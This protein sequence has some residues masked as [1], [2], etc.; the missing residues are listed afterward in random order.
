[1]L[2]F[3]RFLGTFVVV[4]G[5]VGLGVGAYTVRR[6]PTAD[7]PMTWRRGALGDPGSL[8]P[9]KATTVIEGNVLAELFEGLVSRDAKGEL[10]PGVASSWTIDPD[11]MHYVFALRPNARWSNGDAVTAHD[12]VFAFR[13]LMAPAT[14]APYA[15]ILYTLKNGEKVNKGLLP[16][17]ALG[18][19][20]RSDHEL[21][22]E[23]EHPAP[24]FLSQLTHITAKPL[25]EASVAAYGSSF[26]RPGRLVGN[27][28]FVLVGY[29]PNE[30]MDLVKNV[31]FHSAETVALEREIFYPLE[32]RSAA[33]RRFMAGE[34]D[35]YDDVPLEQ[36]ALVR[37]RL[38]EALVVAPVLGAYYFAFDTRRR[39]FD[40]ARVR[41]ALS[42]AIDREFLAE[43]IWRGT[44][45]PLYS[46]VPPGID[47]YGAPTTV[48][49]RDIG[50]LEREDEAR[51]LLRE[52][53]YGEGAQPLEV[54]IR[55]NSSENHR[56]T[57]VAIADM[58]KQVGASTRLLAT[59]A[60]THYALMRE[61]APFDVARA[62]WFADFPDA[63]NFLF[64]GESDNKGLNTPNF[65]DPAFDA[66][67]RAA[68][69]APTPQRRRDILHEAEARILA[70]Q[71]YLVTMSYRSSHLV[72]PRLR[73]FEPNVLGAHYGRYVSIVP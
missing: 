59:D 4:A 60:T 44:M 7:P 58:W 26:T 5:L 10:V 56:A 25:H 43:R 31:Y 69:R 12:F 63:E 20:A 1:M 34:I 13:R 54:E 70:E 14:A 24:Y 55:F 18:V 21:A 71:P 2:R 27:G 16:I 46:L 35:S 41:R 42:M 68:R 17:D 51:R 50:P 29:V 23:L 15:N 3:G 39:P 48:P 6:E 19:R 65:S 33:L 64:L 32:D 49:W 38:P 28:A 11:G 72:S 67:L 52:A 9:H 73:G 37:V 62:G 30:R 57:A 36:I 53:G 22:V 47:S 45:E 66:L 8:D 40:D 61:K